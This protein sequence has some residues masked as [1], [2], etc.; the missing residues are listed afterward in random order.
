MKPPKKEAPARLHKLP[1]GNVLAVS[2]EA[3]P[4]TSPAEIAFFA[5]YSEYAKT[6]RAWLVAYG[7]GGPVLF[8]TNNQ[9][10]AAL[11]AS[12]HRDWIVDLFL[13]G[14]ALQVILAFVNKW[15]AWHLYVGEY[16]SAF[17]SRRSYKFWAWLNERSWIDLSIDAL[18]LVSF[19]V[20]TL[21]AVRVFS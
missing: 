12:P 4:P 19:A 17:Q 2:A 21:L 14:V 8:F 20:S 10:S 5:N 16:D 11:K 1:S 18:S 7:I 6:L 9:L 3:P 15:C 13:L